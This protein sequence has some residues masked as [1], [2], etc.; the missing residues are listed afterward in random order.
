MGNDNDRMAESYTD[1][2]GRRCNLDV[3]CRREPAWAA[4]RIRA[5]TEAVEAGVQAFEFLGERLN[6]ADGAAGEAKANL[7][8]VNEWGGL[9]T[10]QIGSG[11]LKELH[12]A[13]WPML[14]LDASD[15]PPEDEAA[16]ERGE[17]THRCGAP[18]PAPDAVHCSLSAGHDGAH[19]Y[20]GLG[21]PADSKD[22]TGGKE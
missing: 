2:D 8:K 9:L 14:E 19:W 3:M 22:R 15:D 16:T 18:S 13:V 6:Y 1:G 20:C 10:T 7:D 21:W 5:L 4:N 11:R 12:E 17:E